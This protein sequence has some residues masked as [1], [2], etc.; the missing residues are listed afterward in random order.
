MLALRL[1]F[2]LVPCGRC[3]DP[4]V[5]IARIPR[6]ARR[7]RRKSPGAGDQ[8]DQ[9]SSISQHQEGECA[10]IWNLRLLLFLTAVF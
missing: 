5:G 6:A 2:S 10:V 8:L 9:G 1:Y 4:Y 3:S 7:K